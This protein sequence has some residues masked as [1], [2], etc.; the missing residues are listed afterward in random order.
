MSTPHPKPSQRILA[1][2]AAALLVTVA[3][4]PAEV[5]ALSLGRLSLKSGQGEPLRAELDLVRLRAE[6]EA[7]LKARLADANAYQAAGATLQAPLRG[8]QFSL[9]RRED[10]RPYLQI[11]GSEALTEDTLDLIIEVESARG[12][13]VR[14]YTLRLEPG[15][16]PPAAAP[17]P[18]PAPAP[19]AAQQAAPPAE[20]AP[21]AVPPGEEE[22]A[23]LQAAPASTL[24]GLA[25]A[26]LP[27][28]ATL[29]QMM[30]ALLRANPEAFINGNINKLRAG[31]VLV[32]PPR[33]QILAFDRAEARKLVAERSVDQAL[34]P[35]AE[36]PPAAAP[37]APVAEP[38]P[39]AALPVVEVP[40]A[41]P[42]AAAPPLDEAPPVA[43]APVEPPAPAP[44]P[45]EPPAP[46]P[47]EAPAAVQPPPAPAADG[48]APAE[49]ADFGAALRWG[50]PLLIALGLGFWALRRRPATAGAET[51]AAAPVATPVQ[52]PSEPEAPAG[53][54]ALAEPEA[55]AARAEPVAP[56][57]APEPDPVALPAARV[58][59]AP[60]P[61]AEPE[62]EPEPAI[63]LEAEPVPE[64][65]PEPEP[66]P[67][68][69]PEPEPEQP[70]PA[71]QPPASS[72]PTEAE[73]EPLILAGMALD[74]PQPAPPPA[75]PPEAL[76][77][78]DEV[79]APPAPAANEGAASTAPQAWSLF[80]PMA[81]AALPPSQ[82]LP[83]EEVSPFELI[84]T[85]RKPPQDELLELPMQFSLQ[86]LDAQGDVDPVAEAEVYLGYGRDMQAEEILKE[87]LSLD[88]DSLPLRMK[89]LEI[90]ALRRDLPAFE[91]LARDIFETT[92]E[93]HEAWWQTQRLGAELE[94]DHPLYQ[95]GARPAAE[96][97]ARPGL[98][99]SEP[100]ASGMDLDL[101]EDVLP[102]LAGPEAE[103]LNRKLELAEEFL[104]IGDR[105]GAAELAEEVLRAGDASQQARAEALLVRLEPGR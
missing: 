73:P 16:K 89:L 35:P 84:A 26:R 21:V 64:P 87:A 72:A 30:A 75:D 12:R 99:W 101:G 81:G 42:P 92:G 5:K 74:E 24:S 46:A 49:P 10:G 4:L 59:A 37:A 39:P 70:A 78:L 44:A 41:P 34:L 102:A 79:L 38:V 3:V 85:P 83:V 57:Q 67:E 18:A 65:E 25:L 68:P 27:R 105:E 48:A 6:E 66:V 61:Q 36:L 14:D 40:A 29:D 69:E 8:L 20:A 88:P 28:G 80:E 33:E 15:R 60:A 77:P 71:P 50:L 54:A 55:P 45:V 82:P 2:L 104:A 103:G 31:A 93:D 76:Q 13:V 86:D 32:V 100:A 90:H 19:Q 52:A 7:T 9:Q 62:P 43:P 95:P 94:P 56:P 22:V 11:V 1:A 51:A 91:S 53:S 47:A 23:A 63:A 17:A 96:P 97:P 98:P 58:P